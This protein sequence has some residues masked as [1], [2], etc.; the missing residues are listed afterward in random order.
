MAFDDRSEELGSADDQLT[1]LN[2][3]ELVSAGKHTAGPDGTALGSLDDPESLIA[4]QNLRKQRAE[5]KRK[6]RLKI[7]A[8]LILA[9]GLAAVAAYKFWL[10]PE[11]T[12]EED[13]APQ[14]TFV[15]RTDFSTIVTSSGALKAGSTVVV[16]PEVD[17][18]VESI[19]VREGQEVQKGDTLFILK[20]DE[21]DKAVREAQ[22]EVDAAQRDISAAERDAQDAQASRDDAWAKYNEDWRKAN[23]EHIEWENLKANYNT[24][25]EEWEE[26]MERAEELKCNEPVHPGEAP[27]ELGEE[28]LESEY[29]DEESGELDE[30]AYKEAH[31]QWELDKKTYTRW[32]ERYKDYLEKLEQYEAYQQALA[33]AGEE[34]EPAGEEPEYPEAPDDNSLISAIESAN[35][36]VSAAYQAAE[37][38][39]ET[40]KEAVEL[41]GKRKVTAPISGNI[42]E[43]SAKVG[44]SIGGSGGYDEESGGSG[45]G[46]VQICNL[47]QMAVDIDVSEIDILTVKKGQWAKVTFSALPDV[48]V[49]AEVQEVASVASGMGGDGGLVTFHVGLVIP[50]PDPQLRP[51]MTA[52]V[53]IYT[54]DV[55][56]ALVVP[57]T[58]LIEDESGA[59]VEVVTSTAEDG[60]VETEQREVVVGERNST[61]AVIKSGVEEGEEILLSAGMGDI[62]YSE[63]MEEEW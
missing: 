36:G 12:G 42:V 30:K 28:P 38:A 43:M 16:T 13:F 53:S 51:G 5:K 9:C 54:V 31:E 55:K 23:A 15:E 7:A 8:A 26:A 35:D 29:T 39:N 47:D 10:A 58:A 63:Y 11:D 17:G 45:E 41:A 59:Y 4:Y 3:N 18:V 1:T 37:K 34:P 19:N 27:F 21:L 57:L 50:H 2:Q 6:K 22:Q 48:E 44:E 24:L 32:E 40:Y 46:V 33:E 61:D 25:H 14:T 52:N 56:D 60:S 49:D 20:N 62:D